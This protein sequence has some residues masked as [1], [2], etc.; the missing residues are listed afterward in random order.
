MSGT[1]VKS[2]EPKVFVA[3]DLDQP[4]EAEA[5]AENLSGLGLG[6]KLG[7]RLMLREGMALVRSIAQHG[8]VFVDC[9]H[10]D[11]P[12][13]MESAVRAAFDAGAS[14][15]TIHTLAGPQALKK[16]AEVE[17]ELNRERAFRVLAVTIL[18]SFSQDSLPIHLKETK[19]ENLVEA[20]AK[21]SRSNGIKSFVCS[22]H[23]A[24]RLRDAIP[25]SFL[26]TP[27][28]RPE[29]SS[30]GDQVRIETPKAA[31]LA[32]SSALVVGRPILEA[33]DR[34]AMAEKILADFT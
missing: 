34:R 11:I 30:T 7:P 14:F 22:P 12:S 20:L 19:I 5:I 23:E 21:E 16:M 31:K 32:G 4:R 18:T 26:V 29:G 1:L 3:L 17:A 24:K 25:D 15:S 28:I 6:F 2:L 27:G 8:Q 13:T 9:K 10:F 33:S